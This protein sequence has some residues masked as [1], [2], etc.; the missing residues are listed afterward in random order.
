MYGRRE[1]CVVDL[2]KARTSCIPINNCKEAEVLFGNTLFASE[3]K[4]SKFVYDIEKFS[5]NLIYL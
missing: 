1:S 5:R 4:R 3:L 2:E